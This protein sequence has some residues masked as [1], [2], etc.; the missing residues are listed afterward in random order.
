MTRTP[1]I[2]K[3]RSH[4]TSKPNNNLPDSTKVV[5]EFNGPVTWLAGLFPNTEY[6]IFVFRAVR[7]A[8]ALFSTSCILFHFFY[9]S[10]L[11]LTF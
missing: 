1:N 10:Q 3:V 8:L 7:T 6:I 2:I 5:A 9:S 11:A 4:I